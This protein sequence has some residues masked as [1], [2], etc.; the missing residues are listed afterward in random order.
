MTVKKISELPA[1]SALGGTESVPVVQGGATKKVPSSSFYSDLISALIS[2]PVAV[3]TGVTLTSNAFG[4]SHQC[5][6]TT[7]DYTVGLF[8]SGSGDVNKHVEIVV[9][10]ACTKLITLDAGS[11]GTIY[12]SRGSGQTVVLWANE[13]VL[14]RCIGVKLWHIV[15]S[16]SALMLAQIAATFGAIQSIPNTTPTKLTLGT[17]V[18]ES[19]VTADIANSK[20]IIR[21][22]GDYIIESYGTLDVIAGS[23]SG[24]FLIIIMK[25]GATIL[26]QESYV[27]GGAVDGNLVLTSTLYG[28]AAGDYLEMYLYQGTGSAKNTYAGTF[29]CTLAAKE[30]PPW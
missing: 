24:R 1:G 26:N 29:P 2:V 22:A 20:L 15:R 11:G 7:S 6:G 12:H 13:V 19:G 4:K 21:R 17:K 8:A 28:L 5:S 18:I 3:T 16:K 27:A 14:L 25:N 9:D 10:P 30:I 23:G